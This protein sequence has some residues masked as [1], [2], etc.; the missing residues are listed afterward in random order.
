MHFLEQNIKGLCVKFGVDFYQLLADFQVDNVTELSILDLEAFAE[1]NEVD[2]YSLM[3]KPL[4][5]NE[6]LTNKLKKIKLLILDV[7]GVLSDGGM[8]YTESGDYIKKYNAKDGM[9]I[10][11]LQDKGIEVGI[12]SHSFTGN[13]VL[14]RAQTLKIQRV[15]VGKESKLEILAAWCSEMNIGM[16]EVAMIGDDI[17]DLGIFESV[18]MRFCPSDAVQ[19]VKHSADIV[20]SKKGGE[21]CVRELIDNYL[22]SSPLGS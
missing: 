18:G 15:Y 6:T 16:E 13:M 12:I 1:E 8:Y 14:N 22:L 10:M 17:N 20:L 7:D 3:F 5:V 11:R 4:F 21:G 19:V 9:G 2:L